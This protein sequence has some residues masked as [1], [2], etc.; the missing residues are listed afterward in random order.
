M[1]RG[2]LQK[3]V[4]GVLSPP[5]ENHAR[6]SHIDSLAHAQT[7]NDRG[8]GPPRTAIHSRRRQ[9]EGLG[10]SPARGPKMCVPETGAMLDI[11]TSADGVPKIRGQE[12]PGILRHG[13]APRPR[14]SGFGGPRGG[15]YLQRGP[16][17]I[18]FRPN[19]RGITKSEAVKKKTPLKS[20]E[21][22]NPAASPQGGRGRGSKGSDGYAGNR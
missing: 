16:V 11:R 8:R 5:R 13:K 12:R 7:R 1:G 18:R 20:T 22:G 4:F 2:V 10:E 19:G 21:G 14:G 6:R 9:P 3:R 15:G 17:G